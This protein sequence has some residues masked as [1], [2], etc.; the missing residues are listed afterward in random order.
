MAERMIDP[1]AKR[2]MIGVA[3]MHAYA[4]RHVHSVQS[5]RL[6]CGGQK[7]GEAS[8]P[9]EVGDLSCW[10]IKCDCAV[11]G[12][13]PDDGGGQRLHIPAFE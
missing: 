6:F 9:M 8:E 11:F 1:E 5:D 7:Q 4:W 2:M 10:A 12:I 13:F 3:E